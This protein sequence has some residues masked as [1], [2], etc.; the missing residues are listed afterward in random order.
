MRAFALFGV[1]VLAKLVILAGRPV[2]LSGWALLAYFWQD[3][4][5]A[6]VFWLLD[7]VIRRA[8]FGWALYGA[9]VAYVAINVAVARVVSSPL[10]WP[11]LGATRGALADSIKYHATPVNLGL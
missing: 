3:V 5:V 10:T 8:W 6:L 7:R 11:M 4:L 1:F 9:A 2:P